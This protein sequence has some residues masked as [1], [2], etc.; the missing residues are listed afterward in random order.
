V[1]EI[2]FDGQEVPESVTVTMSLPELAFLT[3]LLG[4]QSGSSANEVMHGG[5]A[6]TS[7]IWACLTTVVNS[8]WEDGIDELKGFLR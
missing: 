4:K 3:A 2:V 7:P 8:Y 6:I 5:D 1:R